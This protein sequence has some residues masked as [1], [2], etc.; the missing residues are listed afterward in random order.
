MLRCFVA[1][2]LGP[3]LESANL[4][5]SELKKP[6]MEKMFSLGLAVG[7]LRALALYFTCTCTCSESFR[8]QLCRGLI[9]RGEALDT[10]ALPLAEDYFK[11]ADALGSGGLSRAG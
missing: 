4:N 11:V 2:S 10:E 1:D 6:L 5:G 7:D 3:A 9:G 8:E